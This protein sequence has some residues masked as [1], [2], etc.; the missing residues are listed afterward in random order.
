MAFL[1]YHI[2]TYMK[3]SAEYFKTAQPASGKRNVNSR[4]LGI[5]LKVLVLWKCQNISSFSSMH[6]DTT[7]LDHLV[8]RELMV[9][10][11]EL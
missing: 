2:E 1:V 7:Y 6:G 8:S 5:S 10:L 4:R 11:K 3:C 9:T